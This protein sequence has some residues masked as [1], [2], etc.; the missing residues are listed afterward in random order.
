MSVISQLHRRRAIMLTDKLN[1]Q[2]KRTAKMTAK[3]SLKERTAMAKTSWYFLK[4]MKS[5]QLSSGSR[6]TFSM[7]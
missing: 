5:N 3:K 7:T 6:R 1:S 2:L 4:R